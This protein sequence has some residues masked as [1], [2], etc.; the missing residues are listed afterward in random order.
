MGFLEC[1]NVCKRWKDVIRSEAYAFYKS[2]KMGRCGDWLFVFMEENDGSR[3]WK[4][5]DPEVDRWHPIPP[6]PRTNE[7]IEFSC[8]S[9]HNKLLVIGGFNFCYHS[10]GKISSTNQVLS[11]DPYRQEWSEV[12]C[13]STGRASFACSVICDK[14]YVGGGYRSAYKYNASMGYRRNYPALSSAEV[15]DPVKDRW[16]EL[17]PMPKPRVCCFGVAYNSKFYLLSKSTCGDIMCVFSL[18]DKQ[19]YSRPDVRKN[20]TYMKYDTLVINDHLY[21]IVEDSVQTVNIETGD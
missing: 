5:Y 8:V 18:H 11:F 2:S 10:C 19:W 17:P 3:Y 20:P 1:L 13:M 15:Y 7:L 9:V 4:A 16:D 6:M 21:T 12:A 14:V